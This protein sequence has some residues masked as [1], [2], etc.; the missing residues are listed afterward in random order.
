MTN[1]NF[2]KQKITEKILQELC[3]YDKQFLNKTADSVMMLWW[4]T[5]RQQG[6]RL[7]QIGQEMFSLAQIEYY[8]HEFR[9]DGK[10]YNQFILDLNKK[11]KC[12]YFIG[13]NKIREGKETTF[14]LRI[15]DSKISMLIKI[16]G[17]LQDYLESIKDKYVR[18]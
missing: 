12:P 4:Y 2:T 14:Y 11:I 7:T 13:V 6:F 18:R 17:T 9:Q 8:D 5:G 3:K 10:S 16:Y 15:Y 1:H